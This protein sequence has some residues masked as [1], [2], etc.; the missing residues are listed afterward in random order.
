[1]KIVA[2]HVEAQGATEAE[3]QALRRALSLEELYIAL[4]EVGLEPGLDPMEIYATNERE[5]LSVSSLVRSAAIVWS[6]RNRQAVPGWI[7]EQRLGAARLERLGFI[8]RLNKD[9]WFLQLRDTLGLQRDGELSDA[10]LAATGVDQA[11]QLLALTETDLRDAEAKL[12]SIRER[13]L[14]AQRTINIC[15]KPF[16][17]EATNLRNL[18]L[19]IVHCIPTVSPGQFDLAKPL[20]LDEMKAHDSGGRV[21]RGGA[22]T[23]R[24]KRDRE[25]DL[26]VGIVGEMHAFRMLQAKYGREIVPSSV[27]RSESSEYSFPENAGDDSLGYDFTL[28]LGNTRYFIEVKS[29]EGEA[30][31]FELGSSEVAKAMEVA[32]KKRMRFVILRVLNALS[33]E[34]TFDVLPNPY[35]PSSKE[36]YSIE[37]GGLRVR[38]RRSRG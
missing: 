8:Q 37:E 19:H 25:K 2:S 6:E 1:M 28:W 34:P 5:L 11:L 15:G 26:L 20:L 9:E 29:S 24:R 4:D 22:K 3:I 36:L 31:D 16:E 23:R 17:N 12:K 18:S 27:W 14:R 32:N 21:H 30:E 38:Y 10:L 35:E 7:E 13:E 33:T